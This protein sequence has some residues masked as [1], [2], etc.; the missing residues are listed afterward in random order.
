L[1][2]EAGGKAHSYGRKGKRRRMCVCDISDS[3][4]EVKRRRC[5][6]VSGLADHAE[7]GQTSQYKRFTLLSPAGQNPRRQR[8]P[9]WALAMRSFSIRPVLRYSQRGREGRETA[10][11]D[12]LFAASVRPVAVVVLDDQTRLAE[13][14][15]VM[16]HRGL[17]HLDAEAKLHEALVAER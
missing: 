13:D 14:A 7:V 1:T 8:T 5:G 9:R 2:E 3:R 4:N 6:S 16:C 15:K 11:R 12:R 10:L 17:R